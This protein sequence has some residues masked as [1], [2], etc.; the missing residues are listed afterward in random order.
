LDIPVAF[1]C[2]RQWLP[3][4]ATTIADGLSEAITMPESKKPLDS[5]QTRTQ[6]CHRDT[7][8][9]RQQGHGKAITHARANRLKALA[10]RMSNLG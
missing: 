4:D 8:R 7:Y 1:R 6:S 2:L 3:P 9:P 10:G 5:P